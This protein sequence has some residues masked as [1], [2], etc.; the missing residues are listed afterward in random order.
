MTGFSLDRRSAIVV[1]ALAIGLGFVMGLL[2]SFLTAEGQPG[3]F[4]LAMKTANEPLGY[5]ADILQLCVIAGVILVTA[6]LVYRH[7][8]DHAAIVSDREAKLARLSWRLDFAL[9]A[10]EIGSWDVD[11]TRDEM[12]WDERTRKLFDKPPGDGLCSGEDWVTRLHPDDRE[13]AIAAA[14]ASIEACGRL[15]QDYRIVLSDGTVRHIRDMAAYYEDEKG[16]RRLAGLVWDVTRDIERQE[17][18]ELRRAE[19]E[20]AAEL[21]SQFLASMS[22][23]IRT[24]MTGLMGMLDL[25]SDEALSQKQSERLAIAGA[26]A[27]CLMHILNDVL[28]FSRLETRHITL[29]P[30][31]VVLRQL[32]GEVTGLMAPVVEKRGL[33]LIAEIADTVPD[34][35]SCDPVRLSQVLNNLTSNAAKFTESGQIT[36]RMGYADGVLNVAVEDTGVG[37][38]REDREQ[39]FDKFFQVD[40]SLVRRE[41]GTGLGLAISRELVQLMGGEIVVTSEPGKGSIFAF[42]IAAPESEMPRAVDEDG[43]TSATVGSEP[44]QNLLVAEDNA[45][46]QYLIQAWLERDGHSVTVVENGLEALRAVEAG[47]FD[48][49]LMD[50]QM[51]EMDGESAT[52]AIRLLPGA[53]GAIPIIALTASALSGD[54]EKYLAVGMNDLV[55]KPIDI[56]KLR[57]ALRRASGDLYGADAPVSGSEPHGGLALRAQAN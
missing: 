8:R 45:T 34:S 21:K 41:G 9:A 28:E 39:L 2:T 26:S 11:L 44:A 18:L 50:V 47:S 33:K 17:E 46:N 49:V 54:R 36:L 27:R 57:L 31:P 10:S 53:A 52:R 43:E 32:I 40:S 19:A 42:S 3:L 56:D 22:H 55:A 25:L 38:S 24:P 4:D 16:T 48:A 14:N 51:P 30:Q 23:E 6:F 20:E 5:R 7:G 1:L 37:I 15:V 12:R 35:L 29:H 13:R